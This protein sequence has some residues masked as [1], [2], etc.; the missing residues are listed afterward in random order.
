MRNA[1]LAIAL[2]IAAATPVSAAHPVEAPVLYRV[3]PGTVVLAC[4]GIVGSCELRHLRGTLLL[5]SG[6]SGHGPGESSPP[7]I[8]ESHLELVSQSGYGAPFP[9]PG[10][11]ALTALEGSADGALLRF[12]SPAGSQQSAELTLTRFRDGDGAS[13]GFVLDGFYDE[14]CCDRFRIGLGTVV[15]RAES[16]V[17]ALSFQSGRFRATA[18]WRTASGKQGAGKPVALDDASGYFWF[19][20]PANPEILI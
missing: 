9:A 16:A 18:S 11:L 5:F 2:S 12:E 15:L 14:G 8:L 6:Y 20:M 3:R 17:D 10:D 1:S 7:A 4:G 13:G 19:F